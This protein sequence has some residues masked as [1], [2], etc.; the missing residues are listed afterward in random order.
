MKSPGIYAQNP[1]L[2][3]LV[4]Q[5]AQFVKVAGGYGF[6]EGPVFSRIGFLFFT[7][8][9]SETIHKW[10]VPHWEDPATGGTLTTFRENSDRANGLTFDHQGRLLTGETGPGRVTRTEKD[11]SITVLADRWGDKRLCA[12]NDLVYNINGSIYFSDTP[13]SAMSEPEE[14]TQKAAVYRIARTNIPGEAKLELASEECKM[15]NGVAL[16]PKQDKLYLADSPARNIRVHDILDD[17]SL[18]KGRI[19]AEMESDEQGGPDGLKTDE[20]GNVYSTGPGGI[21]VYTPEGQ[22]LGTLVPPEQPSNLNWGRGFRGLYVTA[23]TS[24]YYLPTQVPGTRTY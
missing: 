9:R 1:A 8:L 20:L 18:A 10:T 7:D 13:Y 24:V 3:E 15:A 19:F 12:P 17:G 22:H 23:R 14:R 16:G 2:F 11:G 6:T 21:W 4:K 5:D